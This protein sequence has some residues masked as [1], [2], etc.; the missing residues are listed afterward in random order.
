[1]TI[2]VLVFGQLSDIIPQKE[3]N[4]STVKNTE[5]LRLEL[6]KQFPA[7]AE[8]NYTIA[9]NKKVVNQTEVLKDQDTVALLPAFSGG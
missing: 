5:E 6:L 2:K 7:I 8:V 3:M 4:F 9:V 1:M